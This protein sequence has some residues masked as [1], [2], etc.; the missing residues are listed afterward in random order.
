MS[1]PEVLR[2]LGKARLWSLST[3][4]T[5]LM[6]AASILISRTHAKARGLGFRVWG[7]GFRV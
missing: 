1:N 5:A 6:L 3:G 7:L 4:A 2:K